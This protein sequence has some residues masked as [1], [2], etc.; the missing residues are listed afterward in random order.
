MRYTV[1]LQTLSRLQHIVAVVAVSSM[2]SCGGGGSGGDT[3]AP[4]T[5]VGSSVWQAGVFQSKSVFANK[6]VNTSGM[7]AETGQPYQSGTRADENNFLRSWTNDL[8]LWYSEVEDVD[9]AK[10]SS[11]LDYFALLKT[12]ALTASNNEKDRFHFTY[13]TADWQALSQSGVSAG[14]G[15][16]W[17]L[18]GSI[19]NSNLRVVVAYN[20]VSSPAATNGLTRGVEVVSVDGVSIATANTQAMVDVLNEGLFPS[21]TGQSHQFVV[22]DL[23]GVTRTV[24]LTSASITSDPVQN[25]HSLDTPT[26]KIGYILFNDHIATSEAQLKDAVAQLEAANINDLVL[27]IRYNGGGYLAIAS[28]LAYMIAGN[29]RT[30]GRTFEQSQFNDKHPSTNPVTGDPLTPTPF[31]STANIDTAIRGQALPTLDLA[32]VFVLTSADTCSASEAVINGLRGVDVE[33]I[34]IGARTCGK[35]YGFYPED[36]CGTTYFSIQ[37]RGVN[38][39]D[40]GDYADGFVPTPTPSPSDLSQVEGCPVT[41]DFQHALGDPLEARF[42]AALQ[43]QSLQTCPPASAVANGGMQKPSLAAI[44]GHAYKSPLLTNRILTRSQ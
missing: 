40:F 12:N 43:Y 28:E 7:D 34:Q 8:Y 16:Q 2:A 32:R 24:S 20:E 5:G 25:V 22:R 44:E 41:D 9:P 19:S 11:T 13:P 31:L 15:A 27:D 4:I 36:N 29:A 10:Y 17:V 6:C 37:F 1:A 14:Y 21:V 38:D 42:A 35:P 3:V 26:G 30:S 18:M 39:K 23:N 33:V